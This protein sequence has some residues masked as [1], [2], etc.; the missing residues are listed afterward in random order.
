LIDL[1][2]ALGKTV[3]ELEQADEYWLRR[4]L[5]DQEARYGARLS[6]TEYVRWVGQVMSQST[7]KS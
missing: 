1:A 7:I 3:D 6:R 2:F 4:M 5:L